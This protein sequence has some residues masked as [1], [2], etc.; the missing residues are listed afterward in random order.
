MRVQSHMFAAGVIVDVVV[1]GAY[2]LGVDSGRE[3]WLRLDRYAG[4]WL[5]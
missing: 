4:H 3:A 5:R 2:Q 1:C